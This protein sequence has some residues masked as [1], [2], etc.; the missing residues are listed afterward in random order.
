L[1]RLGRREFVA[2]NARTRNDN[3]LAFIFLSFIGL[4]RGN[5][6]LRDRGSTERCRHTGK[7]RG[8]EQEVSLP[9]FLRSPF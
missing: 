6:V 1:D 9:P 3:G 2:T 4:L 8:C 7:Q 5:N